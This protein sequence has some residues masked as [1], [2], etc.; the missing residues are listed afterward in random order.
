MAPDKRRYIV[1]GYGSLIYN[2]G[3][4]LY[5]ITSTPG[6]LKGY[7]RRFAQRSEDHRGTPEAPGRVVTLIR[8]Q[9]WDALD[10]PRISDSQAH[11]AGVVPVVWGMAYTIDPERAEEV[12]AY[13]GD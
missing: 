7:V 4:D 9:D 2:P 1:F 12:K 5:P 8:K 3:A 11:P 13:L 10:G 6:Y